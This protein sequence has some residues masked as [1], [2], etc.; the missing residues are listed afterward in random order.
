[1][2]TPNKMNTLRKFEFNWKFED[3]KKEESYPK[4]IDK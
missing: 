3:P 2:D 4:L 1:M